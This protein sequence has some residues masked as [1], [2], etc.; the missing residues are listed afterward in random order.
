Q[1]QDAEPRA[2]GALQAA[3]QSG[4][5]LLRRQR[6]PRRDRSV[7]CDREQER[8]IAEA[9]ERDEAAQG[10][11]VDHQAPDRIRDVRQRGRGGH[12]LLRPGLSPRPYVP[13]TFGNDVSPDGSRRLSARTRPS[14]TTNSKTTS[15]NC[16]VRNRRP[17]TYVSGTGGAPGGTSD[18]PLAS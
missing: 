9:A 5:R 15:E 3:A 8:R 7:L 16:G 10:S 18:T 1:G 17:F 14:S 13:A 6:R 12:Q 4:R 11:A 2:A